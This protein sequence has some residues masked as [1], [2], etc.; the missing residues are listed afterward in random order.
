MFTEEQAKFAVDQSKFLD[1][2]CNEGIC[3][4][5]GRKSLRTYAY[6]TENRVRKSVV[7]YMWC[8]SCRKMKTWLGADAIGVAF[9]DPLGNYSL[10]ERKEMESDIEAFLHRLDQLWSSGE[11]P[12][13][14]LH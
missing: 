2:D 7:T 4:A 5:C 14:K 6:H 12:Q 13:K 9:S 8:F 3:P 1:E 11:L 10:A